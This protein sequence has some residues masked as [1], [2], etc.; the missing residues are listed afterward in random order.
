M[1]VESAIETTWALPTDPSAISRCPALIDQM[2]GFL[3]ILDREDC[4]DEQVDY[5]CIGPQALARSAAFVLIDFF[6]CPEKL[7]G[8]AGYVMSPGV[9]SEE[10]IYMTN[11]AMKLS[12]ELAYQTHSLV[13]KLSPSMETDEPSASY[14]SKITPQVL[15]VIYSSL[16]TF[17][18]FAA[19]E[20]DGAYQYHIYDMCRF[21]EH[22]GTRWRLGSEYL[23][24]VGY[25]D[26][27]NRSA[28]L[29]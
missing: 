15:D 22:M 12:K 5:S 23:G 6:A 3:S 26:S 25:H 2:C 17:Y 18:W 7:S 19:E 13:Q 8:Q 10:E 21:L 4:G 29:T 9:K 16:A 11:R 14:F 24:L 27:K 20:G 28:F 1:F